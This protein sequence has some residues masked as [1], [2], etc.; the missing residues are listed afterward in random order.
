MEKETKEYIDNLASS[1]DKV[2]MNALQI[3]MTLTD[4]KVDWV[5][6]CG[7]ICSRN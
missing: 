5:V 6:M 1:D 4:Q 2:R 3:I 7:M